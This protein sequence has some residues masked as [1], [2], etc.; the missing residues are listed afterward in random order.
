MQEGRIRLPS[1]RALPPA[2][3]LSLAVRIISILFGDIVFRKLSSFYF[4][5]FRARCVFNAAHNFGFIVLAFLEQ[6][7][8]ALGV[9]AW[10]PG[11][12]LKVSG[13]SGRAGSRS[14]TGTLGPSHRGNLAA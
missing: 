12:A 7:F 1:V 8:N 2:I 6:F 5:L 14:A 4:P 13:L 9:G 3:L 11:Q 10:P